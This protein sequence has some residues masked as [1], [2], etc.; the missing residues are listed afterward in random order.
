MVEIIAVEK[1][2][3]IQLIE[4]SVSNAIE[5]AMRSVQPPE[6]MSKDEVAK[7]L[8]KS[9]ATINRWMRKNGL[10]YH[11]VGWPTFNR[12]EVDAWLA[13]K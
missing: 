4:T 8:K 1:A 11:G 12:E 3:L 2:E 7:Y 9:P 13:R 10:P 6:I 5:K